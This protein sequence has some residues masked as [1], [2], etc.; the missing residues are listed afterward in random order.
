MCKRRTIRVEGLEGG[1]SYVIE[2]IDEKGFE[3]GDYYEPVNRKEEVYMP[4]Y[5]QLFRLTITNDYIMR[6]LKISK[7]VN[8]DPN[9]AAPKEI[10][11]IQKKEFTMTLELDEEPVINTS[12]SVMENDLA[13]D[14]G[15]TDEKG[16]FK[17]KNGQTVCFEKIVPIGM[18]YKVTE[19]PDEDYPQLF[20]VNGK[21][22][23]GMMTRDGVSVQFI[24]GVGSTFVIGKEY[25]MSDMNDAIENEY[26]KKLKN[27][28]R[29]DASVELELQ[30]ADEAGEYQVWPTRDTEVLVIDTLTNKK[31]TATWKANR[32]FK[33]QPWKNIYIA[34][35]D[36]NTPY[37]LN[38]RV[39]D[40]HKVIN[41][42]AD[43]QE[44]Y[45]LDIHQ[46]LLENN[47]TLEGNVKE[48]PKAI[49]VNEIRNLEIESEVIKKV[50]AGENTVPEG[51][52]LAYRVEAY[53]GKVW[54]PAEGVEYIVTD[55][56]G[57]IS[58]R[59][60]KTGA[61]GMILMQKR[62]KGTPTVKFV[63]QPVTVHPKN[64]NVGTLRVVE[65]AEST[66][67][68]W[69]RFAGYVD[70]HGKSGIDVWDGI[71]FANSNT[72]HEFE[73]GKVMEEPTNDTFTMILEQ[74]SSAT[75]LPVTE[76]TQI[77]EKVPGSGI[78]YEVYDSASDEYLSESVTGTKGEIYLKAGQ[79]AKFM[80]E[81][82]TEWIVTEKI[83]N[84]YT[85]KDM[86]TN[87]ND[88]SI[89]TGRLDS[90]A[91]V[92]TT[93]E[94]KEDLPGITLTKEMVETGVLDA[95]TGKMVQLKEGNVSIPKK[96]IVDKECYYVTAIGKNA[97]EG[98]IAYDS[99]YEPIFESKLTGLVIP[100]TVIEIQDQAFIY[101][102][103]IKKLVLPD[104]L[105]KIGEQALC[106][107]GAA[108]LNLEQNY[109]DMKITVNP[110]KDGAETFKL[111][112][113]VT[114]IGQMAFIMSTLG[115]ADI[116]E[117]IALGIGAF[118]GCGYLKKCILPD[119]L[120]EIPGYTFQ[121]CCNPALDVTIPEGVEKIGMGAFMGSSFV[122]K[123]P[124]SVKTIDLR[125]FNNING[126]LEP[127]EL[128]LPAS[129]ESIGEEAFSDRMIT[130]IMWNDKT[131]SVGRGAFSNNQIKELVVPS[132][133]KLEHGAFEYNEQLTKVT[134][135]CGIKSIP[136]FC[137]YKCPNLTDVFIS[138]DVTRIGN[139][140]FSDCVSLKNIQLPEKL[141]VIESSAFNNCTAL[142]EITIP[143]SVQH[144]GGAGKSWS[145][146]PQTTIFSSC[147]N[148]KKI[149]IC[150][151]TRPL[152]AEGTKESGL[153]NKW[154]AP[155]ST[156]II[157]A[158]N[159]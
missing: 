1:E 127:E 122:G 61:D 71:G 92:I 82:G 146:Q 153:D 159:K 143:A 83:P 111:P 12:Y 51:A 30:I 17:I 68:S 150:G 86:V 24:N 114:E 130:Q 105:K 124:D 100:D 126:N 47:G 148:L 55:R 10:E 22:V 44:E 41:Y 80:L 91:T 106:Y 132:N 63:E 97:F 157:W 57:I 54:N 115:E 66:D 113:G 151:K 133:V 20:P 128:I 155:A 35:M 121:N 70:N 40:Q 3:D 156:E 14:E 5:G 26:L 2:E 136:E 29:E 140:A 23:T 138:E 98:K 75:E 8:F 135:S 78:R 76:K 90:N 60:E 119:N 77:L 87:N 49:I 53:D 104:S 120:K 142:E 6:D 109:E 11:E 149:I 137:L 19:T 123:I 31:S 72:K 73:V 85:L 25:A 50:L 125:A 112:K 144:I 96:I 84:G 93:P 102:A 9:S 56:E 27:E 99:N 28:L 81:D 154:G 52:Q 131:L 58:D 147:T 117:C 59:T 108:Y 16:Q 48:E 4:L 64:P 79:Y 89:T 129:L 33:I 15:Q 95:D 88:S 110:L 103:N 139:S 152:Y 34:D 107:V 42:E 43:D 46:K 94:A 39:S 37:R 118:N 45:I 7:V 158:D 141:E 18:T 74:I 101:C 36:E 13:I 145:D 116:S 134:F 32:S 69:G 65:V 38:E 21:P 67:A 62:A